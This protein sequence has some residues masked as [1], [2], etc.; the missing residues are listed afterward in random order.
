[1]K[2]THTHTNV[3]I[4]RNWLIDRFSKIMTELRL[5]STLHQIGLE[6]R[7]FGALNSPE[8]LVKILNLSFANVEFNDHVKKKFDKI[9]FNETFSA[10]NNFSKGSSN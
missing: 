5:E 4:S 9:C 1:M 8:I 10:N 3:A 7:E 6:K 2:C